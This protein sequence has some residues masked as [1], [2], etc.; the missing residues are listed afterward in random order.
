MVDLLSDHASPYSRYRVWAARRLARALLIGVIVWLIGS[1][2][3]FS[4]WDRE[5]TCR[6][7]ETI[8]WATIQKALSEGAMLD[9]PARCR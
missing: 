7:E 1:S 3:L 2:I 4:L 5:M 9:S 8:W 6:A